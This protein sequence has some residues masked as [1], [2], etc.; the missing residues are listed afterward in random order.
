MWYALG[1]AASLA[2]LP[3]VLTRIR[4]SRAKHRSLAGHARISRRIARL[5]PFYEYGED[6]FFRADDAPEAV[7]AM[8]SHL[9]Q[10]LGVHQ[11][12]ASVEDANARSIALLA[13]LGFSRAL[14]DALQG[15]ELTA[16]EQLW[17]QAAPR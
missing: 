12:M 17:L 6:D 15:H 16:T 5:M 14:G 7:A 11:A 1:V 4:L 10:R 13:R 2:A 3:S 8:L 9:F